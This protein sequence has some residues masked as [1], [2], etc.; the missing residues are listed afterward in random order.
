M[1]KLVDQNT[2]ETHDKMPVLAWFPFETL[3]QEQMPSERFLDS[4]SGTNLCGEPRLAPADSVI[5]IISFAEMKHFI[6][7]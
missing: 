2:L 7:S 4:V 5:G 3:E 6:T 1:I